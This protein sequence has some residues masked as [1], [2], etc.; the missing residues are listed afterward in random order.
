MRIAVFL[1]IVI[2][3]VVKYKKNHTGK[4]IKKEK[5]WEWYGFKDITVDNLPGN[6][7]D[8][9]TMNTDFPSVSFYPHIKNLNFVIFHNYRY[10]SEA[11]L[12]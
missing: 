2:L 1:S 10:C 4:R 9:K 11:T 6:E 5:S 7:T 8:R 3:T 12:Q